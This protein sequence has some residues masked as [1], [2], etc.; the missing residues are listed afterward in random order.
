M[1]SGEDFR[2]DPGAVS[3]FWK[4]KLEIGEAAAEPQEDQVHLGGSERNLLPAGVELRRSYTTPTTKDPDAT[5]PRGQKPK[6]SQEAEDLHLVRL[7][8]A[9]NLQD[10]HPSTRS[11]YL[12]EVFVEDP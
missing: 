11:Y 5:Q 3:T 8:I 1:V 6:K 2:E 10:G 7:K 4:L 9:K 12:H